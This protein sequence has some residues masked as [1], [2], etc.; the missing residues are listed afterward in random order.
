MKARRIA[1]ALVAVLGAST[2]A[3]CG[4]ASKKTNFTEYWKKN[5]NTT[6]EA[7]SERLEYAVAFEAGSGIDTT[8]YTLSYNNGSYITQLNTTAQGYEY[9]TRLTIDVTYQCGSE[10]AQTFTDVVATRVI[11]SGAGLRPISSEKAVLSHSPVNGSPTTTAECYTAY[12]YTVTSVY[13]EEGNASSTV[14]NQPT[15]EN[16]QTQ[17]SSFTYGKDDY[18]YLDNEQLFLGLR[19]IAPNVTSGKL[20][21]YNPFLKAQQLVKFT[22]ESKTGKTLTYLENGTEVSKDIAYRPATLVLD[23]KTPGGTQTVHVA[24]T[25]DDATKNVNRN[26]ILYMETPISYSLGKLTYTLKSV[27][28]SV[29]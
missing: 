10:E 14:V 27:D 4:S 29:Q 18:S 9:T 3:A 7:V 19:A 25:A 28:N 2:L 23:E 1:I 26:M 12:D 13:D 5:P 24:A 11:F 20:E 21:C 8:G 15:S 6:A 17:A 16:P 22:F